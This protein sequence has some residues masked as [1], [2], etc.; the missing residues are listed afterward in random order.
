MR[1]CVQTYKVTRQRWQRILSR[2]VTYRGDAC[3][4][5]CEYDMRRIRVERGLSERREFAGDAHEAIHM[6]YP[7]LSEDA[8]VIGEEALTTYLYDKLGYRRPVSDVKN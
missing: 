1:F 7:F 3:F 2:Q 8:I 4:S 6:V 5:L